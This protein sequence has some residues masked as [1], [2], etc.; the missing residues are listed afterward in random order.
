MNTPSSGARALVGHTRRPGTTVLLVPGARFFGLLRGIDWCGV[1][2]FRKSLLRRKLI[3]F[4][5]IL[6]T[7]FSGI[8]A[9]SPAA[10]AAPASAGGRLCPSGYFGWASFSDLRDN[11]DQRYPRDGRIWCV[12]SDNEVWTLW[13][14]A[15][16]S[17]AS[18]KTS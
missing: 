14:T 9:I 15:T 11:L 13:C 18:M 10:S 3:A 6:L 8:T 17:Q 16:H 12:P 5:T 1:W 7:G 4:A 2:P